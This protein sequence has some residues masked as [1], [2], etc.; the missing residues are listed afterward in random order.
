MTIGADTS[1]DIRSAQLTP[2]ATFPGSIQSNWVVANTDASAVQAAGELLNP[3]SSDDA[4]VTPVVLPAGCTRVLARLRINDAVTTYT[5]SPVVQ[6]WVTDGNGVPTRIDNADSSAAGVTMTG[7]TSDARDGTYHYSDP[8]DLTGYDAL[9][10]A[11]LYALIETAAA[12]TDGTDPVSVE[13][14]ILALN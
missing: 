5:T 11:K 7:T 4:S 1:V 12:Y 8:I 2:A 9:G 3:A 6:F 10:G 14:M 13:V